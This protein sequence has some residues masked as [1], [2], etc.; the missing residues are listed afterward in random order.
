[1][2]EETATTG[3]VW[4]FG[5]MALLVLALLL[6]A[7]KSPRWTVTNEAIGAFAVLFFA[8]FALWASVRATYTADRRSGQLVIERRI[9][10]WTARTAYDAQTIDQVFVRNTP[11]GSGLYVRFK[12]GRKKR[13][14]VTMEFI[15]LEPFAI[16]LN[17]ALYTHHNN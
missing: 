12:S 14:S 7:P 6:T 1:M 3:A 15:S 10:F 11:K 16:A 17:T 9:L 13:L 8:S 5:A 4:F 2:I